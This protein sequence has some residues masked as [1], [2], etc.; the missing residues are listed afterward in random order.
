MDAITYQTPIVSQPRAQGHLH[1]TVK[2]SGDGSAIDRLEQSGASRMLFPV[3]PRVEAVMLNT[4]GGVT[5]GDRFAVAAHMKSGAQARITTQ[6][7]ERFYRANDPLPGRI[8]TQ[9]TIDDDSSL[10]WLPQESILFEGAHVERTFRAD[11]S[12]TARLL[13]VEPLIFGRL[14]MG[15]QIR[16][17]RLR[18]DVQIHRDGTA[19]FRD[20][21][22]W[23]G[24]IAQLLDRPAVG[25]GARASALVLYAAPDAEAQ[26]A[27]LRRIYPGVSLLRDGL[28]AAR[29][30]AADGFGLRQTLIPFL[31]CLTD[32]PRCWSL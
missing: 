29:F 27:K 18:D 21:A 24:D 12:A 31:S 17:A 4:S 23:R 1:L 16:N 6:A 20:T 25:A 8:Q 2:P 3:G 13:F 14:A 10:C 19:I 7:S 5:G 32:L 15:E 9:A 26:L 30:L 11:L 22:D 28:L